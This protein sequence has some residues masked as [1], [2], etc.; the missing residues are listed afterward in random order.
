MKLTYEIKVGQ[1]TG[2]MVGVIYDSYG[3]VLTLSQGFVNRSSLIN[4]LVINLRMNNP[5]GP[6]SMTR[7]RV[8]NERVYNRPMFWEITTYDANG[9]QLRSGQYSAV[10]QEGYLRGLVQDSFGFPL[11]AAEEIK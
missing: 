7:K 4:W 1:E 2:Y 10:M 11:E 3:K 6:C 9:K 5:A 8:Y